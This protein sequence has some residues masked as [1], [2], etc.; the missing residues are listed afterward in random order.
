MPLSRNVFG[1]LDRVA[2]SSGRSRIALTYE[3][4][5]RTFEEL[6]RRALRLAAGLEALGIARRDRVAV[7]LGNGHEWPE[8]FFA[9]AAM[10]AVCVPVNVLLGPAE[11]TQ[12]CEDSDVRCLIVGRGAEAVVAGMAA[13]PAMVVRVGLV[14]MP[15]GVDAVDYEDLIATAAALPTAVMPDLDDLAVLYY[16]SGTTGRPK[17]AA[18]THNGVLWNSFHQIPDLS[19]AADD[20]Y[21]VVPSLSW[22]AGFHDITL[23]LAWLGG[24]SVL[25]PTGGTTPDRIVDAI[26]REHVTR[27]L[28]VPTLLRQFLA[29]KTAMEALRHSSLRWIITGAEP[30]PLPMIEAMADELPDCGVVQ[31]YGLSEFPTIATALHAHEAVSHV[32][33]AGRPLAGTEMAVQGFDGVIS[34][35]G[36][37]EV[38]LRS[39]A[40]MKEYINRAE[41]TADAFAD[42]W[43]H[44]GDLGDVDTDGFLTITGRKKDL[45]ISGGLNIYPKEVED[46]LYRLPGVV[47]ASVV[48]V[49]DDRWGEQVVAVIVPGE[50]GFDA[51]ELDA[52]C[53]AELASFKRPRAVVLRHEP[54]PRNPSG[55]VLKRE[56]R[57]WAQDQL[58]GTRRDEGGE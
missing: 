14:E 18:H 40:T 8:I 25:M 13:L 20:V 6:H 55:K 47:E 34:A 7:L 4:A 49:P 5:G 9:L 41:E 19:I 28:L 3:G 46:V 58:A 45:I 35:H 2:R 12:V 33:S 42:G 44:T 53:R 48:G 10:G 11:V 29:D 17:A 32:G 24:R 23:A 57:P 43:L 38:L 15:V 36:A 26:T 21:L 22:A 50:V 54:L 16:S 39:A 51:G 56:L 30:V 27:V 31:G 37:G 52:L 1:I